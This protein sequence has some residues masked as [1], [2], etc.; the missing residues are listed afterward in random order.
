M[1]NHLKKNPRY[2]SFTI[3]CTYFAYTRRRLAIIS[4]RTSYEVGVTHQRR[5]LYTYSISRR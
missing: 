2:W 4:E 3:A 5:T 1:Y